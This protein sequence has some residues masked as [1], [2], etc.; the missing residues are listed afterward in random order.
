MSRADLKRLQ[1]KIAENLEVHFIDETPNSNFRDDCEATPA[2]I[3]ECVNKIAASHLFNRTR[4][5]SCT[6]DQ[7]NEKSPLRV[8]MEA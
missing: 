4:I 8:R 1:H 5:K 3:A 6:G 2:P 7:T